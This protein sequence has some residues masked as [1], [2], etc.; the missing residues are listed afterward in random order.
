MTLEEL[1]DL[2]G[3]NSANT[4]GR[5][6]SLRHETDA[7]SMNIQNDLTDVKH[8]L[9]LIPTVSN[10]QKQID[11]LAAEVAELRRRA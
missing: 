11:S 8:G 3:A 6:D 4:N 10:L 5:I 1:A 2:I 9:D 7:Q